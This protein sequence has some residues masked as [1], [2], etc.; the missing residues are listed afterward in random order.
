MNA[1]LGEGCGKMKIR[2]HFML[3]GDN[4]ETFDRKQHRL[5]LTHQIGRFCQK[6]P[7]G[8]FNSVQFTQ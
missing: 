6:I 5:M 8:E 4:R 3:W 2:I 7:G 1:S